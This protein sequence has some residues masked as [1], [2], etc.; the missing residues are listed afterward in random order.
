MTR[1]QDPPERPKLYACAAQDPR[2]LHAFRT[3]NNL[4]RGCHQAASEVSGR[5]ERKDGRKL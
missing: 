1:R 4:P 2:R 3:E 5:G